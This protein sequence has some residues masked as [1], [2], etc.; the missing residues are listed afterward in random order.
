MQTEQLSQLALTIPEVA[1]RLGK[2]EPATRRAIEHGQLPARHWGRRVI[3][4]ADELEQFLRG[5]P[6]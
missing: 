4:L 6:K 5:L 1:K 2:T 3:V